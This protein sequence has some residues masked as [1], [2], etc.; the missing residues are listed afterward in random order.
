MTD[1]PDP[2]ALLDAI[3]RFLLEELQPQV[4]DRR[5]GFRL[6][7]AANLATTVAAELRTGEERAVTE[8]RRW[9][10]LLPGIERGDA[11]RM[12][13]SERVRA[14]RALEAELVA[15]LRTGRLTADELQRARSQVRQGLAEAL[16]FVNPRFDTSAE[17]E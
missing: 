11:T 4:T 3:A 8:L 14:I 12:T 17:V 2:P 1:R 10:E 7:I 15:R 6:L 16:A 9:Q 5:L 13:T